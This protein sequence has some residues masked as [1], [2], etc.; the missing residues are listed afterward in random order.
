LVVQGWSGMLMLLLTMFITDLVEFS[1]RGEYRELSALLTVDPGALG[2][3]ILSGLICFNVIAQMAIRAVHRRGC[4][5]RVFGVTVAYVAFFV[6]HQL[7]H[8]AK[9][10]GFDIHF[11]LDITH[12]LVGLWAC[13]A[14][15][16]WAR[17]AQEE[18]GPMSAPAS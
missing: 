6:A 1:M 7:V 2:L 9:G 15:W 10:D 17:L 11:I 8:L 12:H 18:P 3:W 4:R 14:A 5:W 13:W 16:R